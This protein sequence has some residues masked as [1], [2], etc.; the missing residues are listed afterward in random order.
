M[1]V[2]SR[3]TG[4]KRLEQQDRL[5]FECLLDMNAENEALHREF[6]FFSRQDTFAKIAS[7]LERPHEEKNLT[8]VEVLVKRTVENGEEYRRFPLTMR[9][10]EAISGKLLTGDLDTI[11]VRW[12]SE[13]SD[14]TPSILDI[15]CEDES[16]Q[17]AET[18]DIDVEAAASLRVEHSQVVSSTAAVDN[19]VDDRTIEDEN[20]TAAIK[21]MDAE[22]GKNPKKGTAASTKVRHMV[23]KSKAR[24]D[25]KRIPKIED[26]F[27]LEAVVFDKA[28][29]STS[30][31]YYF[32][33]HRDPLERIL[34]SMVSSSN[35]EAWEFLVAVPQG[36]G[37]RYK[38]IHDT[39]IQLSEAT[40]Q[41]ILNSFDRLILRP[42]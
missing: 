9:A 12:F 32:L 33:A 14:A 28:T 29:R 11:V 22:K 20:L 36:D 6:R 5:Y 16:I 41:G 25:A 40:S 4:D 30:S 26:R 3:A 39:S 31:N 17:L 1:L 37:I 15:D 38:R 19:S 18:T 2:K 35:S 42:R 24:G 27:F 7:S 8:N 21:K 10:Y 13:D 34:Q 23:M